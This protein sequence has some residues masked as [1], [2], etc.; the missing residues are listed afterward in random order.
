MGRRC[1]VSARRVRQCSAAAVCSGCV[2]AKYQ[3]RRKD[4]MNRKVRC[5]RSGL[6]R[7]A[8]SACVGAR[9]CVHMC[10][11][12]WYVC[13]TAFVCQGAC[14]YVRECACVRALTLAFV[15]LSFTQT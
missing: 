13:A 6:S 4:G 1:A 8:A 12:R 7:G 9:A 2:Q 15:C 3:D 5:Q 10:L 14:A 11:S